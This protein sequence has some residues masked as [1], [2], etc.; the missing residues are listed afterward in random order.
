MENSEALSAIAFFGAIALASFLPV[1]IR[2]VLVPAV[3]LEILFGVVLG[4]QFLGIVQ[5]GPLLESLS[6]LGL[7][8]LFFMAGFEVEPSEIGGRPLRLAMRTWV[9]SL[10]I[11]LAFA[12]GAYALGAL[13]APGY[14]AL[15]ISTTAIGALMPMLRDN[16]LLSPPYG[17]HAL[18]NGS[19]G[20]GLPLVMLSLLL[21]G[22][23]GFGAQ[24]L[25]LVGFTL[26]AVAAIV[27]ADRYGEKGLAPIL[28]KTMHHSGQ[29]PLRFALFLTVAFVFLGEHFGLDLVLGAFVAGAVA[30]AAMPA[31]LREQLNSKLDGIGY[32]F[33]IPC[34]FVFSGLTLDIAALIESPMALIAI[35]IF[36]AVMLVVRGA[37]VLLYDKDLSASERQALAL[38]NGTQLPLVVAITA[39]AV[40]AGAMPTWLAASMVAAGVLT[41]LVYP[42]LGVRLL[43]ARSAG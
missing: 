2:F 43:R 18:A 9:L 36:A 1:V 27:L 23:A 42:A 38:H 35:P 30:R 25:I 41:V 28:R 39:I 16:E 32:G 17:P 20:E 40:E 11:A 13:P 34:F 37:P 3:V 21:A 33:L 12:Y 15:A 22:Y 8:V 19:I 14:V 7:A 6:E 31:D 5:P 4:P 29:F 24:A 10:G 26:A